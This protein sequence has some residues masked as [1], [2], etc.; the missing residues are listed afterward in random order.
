MAVGYQFG[1]HLVAGEHAA[2]RARLSV[3]HAGHHVVGVRYMLSAGGY[4]PHELRIARLGMRN[5]GND[6][7]IA[8]GG[9]HGISILQLRRH[10]HQ[11]DGPLGRREVL[12]QCGLARNRR[13]DVALMWQLFGR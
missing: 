13:G 7:Q 8:H 3:M 2:Y 12:Q 6:A 10:A 5:G 9:D 1:R 11:A 4:R